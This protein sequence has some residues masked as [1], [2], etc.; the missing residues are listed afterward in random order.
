VAAYAV[1]I[2]DEQILLSRL[3]PYLAAGEMW[4]LP[5]GGIDFGE[6]PRDAVVREV[7]EET[8]LP[9]TVGERAW[10]DSARRHA[11]DTD[12]DMHSVRIIY[13]GWVPVDAPEPR[14]V[15][16]NGSTVDAR[17]LP[18]ADVESGQ[19]PVVAMVRDALAQ[20]HPAQLQR[21]AAYALVT[22]DDKILL[23][24]ISP[25]GFN[26]GAWS[27][28]GGGVDHGEPPATALAREVAEETGL[29]ATVGELLGVH[30]VHFTGTAPN[31]RTE[32]F[33]GVHLVFRATVSDGR[34]H[35]TEVDGTTDRVEWVPLASVESGEVEVLEVVRAALACEAQR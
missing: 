24:R 11:V 13:D 23:A 17:W 32:D 2:R 16:V 14:V 19:V 22:R 21:L 30:D 3:A 34:P 29:V 1:I 28:P 9:V 8:G 12:T 25:R 35:V 26:T 20:R 10:I 31:G 15:E 4:T 27:L 33:H 7:H 18:L 6:H 5:G